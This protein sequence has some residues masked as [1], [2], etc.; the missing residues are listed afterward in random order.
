MWMANE[1][2]IDDLWDRIGMLLNELSA[3][4]API[5][6]STLNTAQPDRKTL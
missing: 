1:R 4:D 2:T 6:L 3:Q 5:T